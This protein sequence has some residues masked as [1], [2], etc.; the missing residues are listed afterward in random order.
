MIKPIIYDDYLFLVTKNN[1]LIC[2]DL[3]KGSLIYS[4]NINKQISDYFNIKQR[5]AIFKNMMIVNNKIFIFLE[6]SYLLKYNAKGN[7]ESIEK[8]NPKILSNILIIDDSLLYV[9]NK[10]K[11]L[12]LN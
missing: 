5:S 3:K 8:I 6:N 1:L 12:I 9:D 7:L 4:Y 10:N 2:I 11:L